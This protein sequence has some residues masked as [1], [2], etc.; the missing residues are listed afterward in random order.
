MN[1]AEEAAATRVR[2]ALSRAVGFLDRQ[3]LPS[4]ELK[5]YRYSDLAMEA[6]PQLKSTPY[7]TSYILYSL[8]YSDDLRV[9]SIVSRGST[10]L[11]GE[12]EAPGLWRYFSLG[13]AETL[14]PDLDDTACAAYVLKDAHDYLL[15]GLNYRLFLLN[16]DADGRFRTF[17]SD[18][19]ANNVCGLVNANVLLYLGERP[20]TLAACDYLVHLTTDGEEGKRT[21]YGVDDL[22][23]FYV[24]S[25]AYFHGVRRLAAARSAASERILARQ[26]GDGGLGGSVLH[27]AMAVASLLNLGYAEPSILAAAVRYLLDRQNEDGSWPRAAYYIDFDEGYYGSEEITTAL[28]IEALARSSPA[29]MT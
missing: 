24:L 5:T 17:L 4:G 28:C 20:E 19:G 14:P 16:R 11:L 7:G 2:T 3:Q 10:F 6:N 21:V 22:L 13:N 12:M 29:P 27:T 9:P 25:R 26:D 15:L 23:F 1:P 18:G 8:A